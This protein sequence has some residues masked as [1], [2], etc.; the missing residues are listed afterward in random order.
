MK[1]APRGHTRNVGKL[2]KRYRFVPAGVRRVL[3]RPYGKQKRLYLITTAG[4]FLCNPASYDKQALLKR[5]YA[6]NE[7]LTHKNQ[8]VLERRIGHGTDNAI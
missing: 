7:Q 6:V 2:H 4:V 5:G 8:T 3:W 1:G